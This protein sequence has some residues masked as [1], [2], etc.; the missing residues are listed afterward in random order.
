[1]GK[2]RYTREQMEEIIFIQ[3]DNLIAIGEQA[4]LY[5]QQNELLTKVNQE[6]R[7]ELVEYKKMN[8]RKGTKSDRNKF[9]V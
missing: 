1:M 3:L 2:L 9:S 4:Q 7:E 6:L 5:K 8:N